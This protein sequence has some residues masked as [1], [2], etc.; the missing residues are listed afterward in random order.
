MNQSIGFLAQL[1][2]AALRRLMQIIV[3]SSRGAT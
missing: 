3:P 2:D 1:P